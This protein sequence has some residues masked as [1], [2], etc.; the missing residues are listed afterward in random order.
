MLN[1]PLVFP[2]NSSDGDMMC[3]NVTLFPDSMVEC[4]EEFTV[5]LNLDTIKDSLSLG[6]NATLVTLM[7]SEGM[8]SELPLIQPPF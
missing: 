2:S 1:T 5:E 6:D 8:F 3:A 7:D 4:E